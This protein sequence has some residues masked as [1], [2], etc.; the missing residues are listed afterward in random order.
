MS[1]IIATLMLDRSPALGD[2][3]PGGLAPS[4]DRPDWIWASANRFRKG[5]AVFHKTFRTETDLISATLRC[6]GDS[7]AV[8]IR[9]DQEVIAALEP[10][11]PLMMR[12]VTDR[13]SSG[14]H[15]ITIRA[16]SVEGP[17][18]FFLQLDLEY[19]N[20]QKRVV[21]S[22]TSW[23]AEDESGQKMAVSFGAVDPRL[24]IPKSRRVGI[25]AADNYEQWKQAL[26]AEEG[27]DPASFLVTPGFEIELVRSAAA[28]E[29]SWVALEFD[30]QGRLIIAKESQGLLRMTLS[31]G[32]DEVVK[33][34]L[35]EE[36]LKEC[37]GLV[38]VDGDLYV[39]ANNSKGMYRL[40]RTDDDRFQ[41]PELLFAT[42]G[43][44]GHGR[45][46]LTLGP[47]GR[48]YSIH[49]DAVDIP[50]DVVD[51]TSP[52]RDAR[53][54]K[55]TSEGHLLRVDP[56]SGQVEVLAAG[57]RN[58][59]GIDFHASG[60]IF[61]Y[62]ADAEYDMGSPWYRPTRVSH[63][64]TGGDYGWRGVTKSWP[65]YYPDH[66]DNA[67]PNLDIGKGSPTAV[68]FGTASNFPARFRDALFILDW[69]YGRVIA[70]HCLP[71][72]SSHLL[73]AET[74]L[75]GR[76]LNVTDLG[77]GPDG[78]MYL[79]TGGRKT[80][81][82]LYRVRYVGTRAE[83]I[84]E[85]TVQQQQR[86][87]FA[88]RQRKLRRDLESELQ[89]PRQDDSLQ[90]AWEQLGN[91]DPWIRQAAVHLLEQQPV[92]KWQDRAL[93][94]PPSTTA[95]LALLSLSRSA[96]E[97]S[98]PD[99]VA[100][101]N[102]MPM[103][104]VTRSPREI[105]LQA[106]SLCLTPQLI[107]SHP[108]LVSATRE[109]LAAIYS[110]QNNAYTV[111]RQLSELLVRLKAPS[112]VEETI[113]LLRQATDQA[114]Q[115]HYLYVLRGVKDGWNIANRK[116]YFTALRQSRHYQSGAGMPDFIRK[117]REEA[118]ST[119]T[120]AEREELASLIA[121]EPETQVHT[122]RKPRPFVRKWTVEDILVKTEEN[123][124]RDLQRGKEMFAA[125]ACIQCHR[126]GG[127][128]VLIGPD[129][130]AAGR[131]FSRRDLL[132]SIIEPSKVIAENYRSVQIV[133]SSGQTYV[134]QTIL[135]GD[136]R[137]PRLRLATDPTNPLQTIEI[138]K[139]DIEQQKPSEVSWMP[140]GL[141]DTLS[142]DE[143]LD[144][145]AFIEAAAG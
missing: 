1:L 75:K 144:L 27:T 11:D 30:P 132:T 119:L 62:D 13:L 82:A 81:S 18:A 106:Y 8:T 133:T 113:P 108:N 95:L 38:F 3:P 96:N 48:I 100:R 12:D 110:T 112:V 104:S 129:L 122:P 73:S 6:V 63:L 40:K 64:V 101:L 131:R 55:K 130:T 139:N 136:Y 58:P 32:G 33:T 137:S 26:G 79:V 72:G 140:T 16:E 21:R 103:D 76:P 87:K 19:A 97:K 80:L 53:G 142:R 5:E 84:F 126:I 54:G 29:D 105:A 88:S 60:D 86:E 138:D 111:N 43:G 116:T 135:A 68:K 20:G 134:G 61:T 25:A 66:A 57:L 24:I 145:V 2:Q 114:E 67:R 42:S 45:N 127:T 37:R 36:T 65:S 123:S 143:I 50:T 39:N 89:Q 7:A 71:R 47:D 102:E 120:D 109:K 70:V 98:F 51:Y 124:R 14:D 56:Q 10:Y 74:F 91:D 44:V 41:T 28:D 90:Q 17:S 99:I 115:M 128:G 15:E 94:A 69:A 31:G 92:E 107:A 23:R 46:D 9:I 52:F 93:H 118:L 125:A 117:I 59:F 4:L 83:E 85:T 121:E 78:S 22:D 35:I 141:L 49:G 77:F 34:E